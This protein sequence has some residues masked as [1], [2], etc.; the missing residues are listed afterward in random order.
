M[1]V[2]RFR[3]VP[4]PRCAVLAALMALASAA[5]A[6][7]AASDYDRHV[8]FDNSVTS[9]AYYW[10]SG[11]AVA[12]ST[13]ELARGKMPV[14]RGTC[15]SPPNC[16]RLAWTSSRGGDWRVTL[17]LR[18]HWGGLNYSGDTLSFWVRADKDIAPDAS[19]LV[20]VV[21]QDGEGSPAIRLLGEQTLPGGTWMRIRLPFTSFVGLF[22]STGEERFDP[23]RLASITILQ[24]LDDGQPHALLIDEIRIDDETAADTA[25]PAAPGAPAARGFDRHIELSWP[26][27]RDPDLLHY[28]IHRST[29]GMTF[30]P[31]GIQ[32]AGRHRYV[33]FLGASDRSATYRLTAVDTHDNESAP[34][35]PVGASTRAMSDD[36]L[37][38][39]VQEASFRYYWDGAHPDAGMA[40]EVQPGEQHLIALGG[41]GFGIMSLIVAAERGFVPR[42]QVAERLQKILRFLAKADRFHGV[43]PHFLDGRTGKAWPLFGPR[44][45]GGDLVET[46]FLMQGLL[47]ARQYFTRE[48]PAER[49][50]VGT[51]TRFWREAEWD[52]YRKTPDS[53]VL[54]WHWS[55][56][57]GFVISHP[58]IGWNETM[59]IY[60]L[61]IASP[62]HAVPA[63][64]YHTGWAGQSPLHV[65]Y[66]R[67]WSRTT[68]GDHYVNGKEYF[69]V[70]LDV[71]IP[72]ELFFTHFSF[73]GFDPRGK[74]DRYTNYFENNRAMA[75]I[76]H[77]YAVA[78]PR[79]RAGYGDDAWGRSAGVNAGSGRP[80]PDGD[81][82]TLTVHGALASFP[83]TPEESMK[84][85]K[86]FYRDLGDRLWGIY[87][88]RDGFNE[89]E[90]WF[91]DVYMGLNQGPTAVMIENHR[92]GL[93]WKLFMS[94]P[95]IGPAL[96]AIGF[97]PE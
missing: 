90:H 25:P 82:G 81:N 37:L 34:S 63:S 14:D 55:P 24:G 86:H 30:V 87:G 4:T 49:E 68:D 47:A 79:G 67:N 18:R 15:V 54:Y 85:L 59:I 13:L 32:K 43:W 42:E 70:T 91:E 5:A 2:R 58:L 7:A 94:N 64:M 74:R 39:M 69:G 71:G 65:Q 11:S 95:E 1:T 44:D 52:W 66:R 88:F 50:I 22:E 40:L 77:A 97:K 23:K 78:N 80:A 6:S 29:D 92:S 61:A 53:D 89:T 51:V 36:E 38:T 72:A 33:D 21:D 16:L 28:R 35:P 48:T 8:V 12:P 57:H 27:S 20:F 31:I 10:G 62:T 96:K 75:R 45:D 19:P 3:N 26:A 60:L 46:A 17:G 9:D 83:Y 56:T 76:H 93:L 84:A 73:M 41:S